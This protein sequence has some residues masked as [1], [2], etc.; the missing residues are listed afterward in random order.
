MRCHGLKFSPLPLMA[1]A[2]SARRTAR[3]VSDARGDD[4]LH[5]RQKR[6]IVGQPAPLVC[7]VAY[8]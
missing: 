1:H 8:R 7:R 3:M 2:P 5:S 6:V 4:L